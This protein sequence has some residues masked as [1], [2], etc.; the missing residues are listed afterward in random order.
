MILKEIDVNKNWG[1]GQG[2]YARVPS[3]IS[4]P[5]Q[6]WGMALSDNSVAMVHTKL[7]L[8]FQDVLGELSLILDALDG[9]QNLSFDHIKSTPRYTYKSPEDIVTEYLT[10]VFTAFI[11]A[12]TPSISRHVRE[13]FPTDLVIT[14]PT[15]SAPLIPFG[16][17]QN[18]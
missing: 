17:G 9:M 7:E 6:E 16:L 14:V 10:K 1:P 3:V 15:V 5:D 4:Y 13:T 2:N 18:V 11:G 8:D 12:V